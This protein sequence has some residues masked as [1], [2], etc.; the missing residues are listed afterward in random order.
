MPDTLGL[1]VRVVAAVGHRPVFAA[2]RND[3]GSL[4][5]PAL[6]QTACAIGFQ[7]ERRIADPDRGESS[8]FDV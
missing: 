7:L 8:G 6:A 5:C 2:V 4:F 1:P 3:A